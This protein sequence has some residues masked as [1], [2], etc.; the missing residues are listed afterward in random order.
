MYRGELSEQWSFATLKYPVSKYNQCESENGSRQNS[1]YEPASQLRARFRF[2]QH[3][4]GT[5]G[6]IEIGRLV[7]GSC[8][9][10]HGKILA[11]PPMTA[12]RSLGYVLKE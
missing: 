9:V 1:K 6:L 3:V 11:L 7:P 4:N 2:S 12:G 5:I 10:W 8:C